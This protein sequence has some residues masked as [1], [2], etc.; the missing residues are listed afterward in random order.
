MKYKEIIIPKILHELH[1]EKTRISTLSMVYLAG[2]IAAGVVVYQVI[3]SALP[4]WKVILVG[5]LFLDIAG[6]VVANLSTSTNQ[7]YQGKTGLRLGFTLLHILH[8]ALFIVVLPEAWPYFMF[9]GIFTLASVRL[10]NAF[11]DIE[12]QQN[13]AALLVVVGIAV[14]F[15]FDVPLVIFYSFA[16]LFMIKLIL[17]FAVRR[18]ALT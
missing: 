11:N 15:T 7:Y 4:I 12:F 17:G 16:P 13:L 9:V 2:L 6:G 14:S 1:G 8:P 5:L 10:V 18:P 3:P